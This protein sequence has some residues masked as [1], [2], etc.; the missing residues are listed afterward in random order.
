MLSKRKTDLIEAIE[1]EY[2]TVSDNFSEKC[3]VALASIEAILDKLSHDTSRL[4]TTVSSVE[5]ANS[6]CFSDTVT[7]LLEPAILSLI[8]KELLPIKYNLIQ[9]MHTIQNEE[10]ILN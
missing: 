9:L 6:I 5:Q 1:K 8:E 2:Y 7:P 4:I 3:S 10:N